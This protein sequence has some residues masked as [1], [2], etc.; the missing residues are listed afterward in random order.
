MQKCAITSCESRGNK[1]IVLVRGSQWHKGEPDLAIPI[2][3]HHYKMVHQKRKPER[4]GAVAPAMPDE[5]DRTVEEAFE[6]VKEIA[7]T[8]LD[9]YYPSS[10]DASDFASA[11]VQALEVAGLLPIFNVNERRRW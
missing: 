5:D 9:S 4:K 2:C 3:D 6:K 11:I 1:R 7:Q 10:P 8:Y